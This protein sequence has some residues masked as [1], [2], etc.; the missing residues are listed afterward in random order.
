MKA[1]RVVLSMA[2]LQEFDPEGGRGGGSEGR[3]LCPLCG[4]HK[5]RDEAHRCLSVR[6]V[7]GVWFCSR[8]KEGGVLREFWRDTHSPDATARTRSQRAWMQ[9]ARL[10]QLRDEPSS[11]SSSSGEGT[12]PLDDRLWKH[13]RQIADTDGAV[14][15]RSRGIEP[16][17]AALSDVRFAPTWIRPDSGRSAVLFPILDRQERLVAMQGRYIDERQ[18]PKAR[19]IGRLKNGVF[20]AFCDLGERRL[21]PFDDASPA[22]IVTEAPIDALSLAMAGFPALALCGTNIPHWF[23]LACGLREVVLATDADEKGDS[24]ADAHGAFLTLYGARC[25]RLRPE[26]FKDWNEMLKGKGPHEL[27]DWLSHSLL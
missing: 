1:S 8:C 18:D 14:Y 20:R 25:T 22:I 16:D 6:R 9:R 7:D 5:E 19:T 15:L 3:W 4:V 12:Q 17:V 2:L 24:A 21:G 23:H 26:G 11:P 13:A 10:S 27:C